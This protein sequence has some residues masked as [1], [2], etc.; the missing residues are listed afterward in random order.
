MTNM[1]FMK[2]QQSEN[3]HVFHKYLLDFISTFTSCKSTLTQYEKNNTAFMCFSKLAPD[4]GLV[5]STNVVLSLKK[6]ATQ[7]DCGAAPR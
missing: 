1:R 3:C 7:S 6:L 2:A 4:W 5:D